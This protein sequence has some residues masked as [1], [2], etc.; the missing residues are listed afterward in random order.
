MSG[1]DISIYAAAF[2]QKRGEKPFPSG[3]VGE[4]TS[5]RSTSPSGLEEGEKPSNARC[6]CSAEREESHA[7]DKIGNGEHRGDSSTP[8][9]RHVTSAT[10]TGGEKF[11]IALGD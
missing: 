6:E 1:A 11:Q 9:P 3:E 5:T 7:C 10:K 2:T 8:W 4:Y